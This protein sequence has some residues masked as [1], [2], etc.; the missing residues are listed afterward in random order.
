LFTKLEVGKWFY[1][2]DFSA[3]QHRLDCAA[4]AI[5]RQSTAERELRGTA[6]R[7]AALRAE[8]RAARGDRQYVDSHGQSE[9]AF[10]FSYLLGFDLSPRLKAIA[11]QRLY[12]PSTADADQ[13]S[14]LAPV[15]TREINWDLVT[16]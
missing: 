13:Y 8:G 7:K 15:L 5:S 6:L 11:R 9:V 16:Q 12:L 14:S 4:N 2:H 3:L 10:A 1:R